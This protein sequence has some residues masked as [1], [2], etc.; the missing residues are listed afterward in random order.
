MVANGTYTKDGQEKTSWKQVGMIG[1]SQSG[2]E[3]VLLDPTVN[4]AGFTRE[5]GKDMLI[6]SVFEDQ[7]K[8]Q[9]YQQPQQPAQQVP[10]IVIEDGSIPF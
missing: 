8:Q 4:L 2:K 1:T 3:F 10:E 6:C 9:N 7:P 5:A